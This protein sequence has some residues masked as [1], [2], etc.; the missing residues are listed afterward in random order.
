[1]FAEWASDT[2][3]NLSLLYSS[4]VFKS[5]FEESIKKATHLNL[6]GVQEPV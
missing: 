3:R 6:V 1:M 4:T 5:T 2:D